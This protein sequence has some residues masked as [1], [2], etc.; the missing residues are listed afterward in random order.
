MYIFNPIESIRS[1]T[2]DHIKRKKVFKCQLCE[3]KSESKQRMGQHYDTKHRNDI[4]SEMDGYRYFYFTLTGKGNGSCVICKSE[5]EFNRT[6][7][8]YSRFCSNPECK[9]RYREEFKS[10][11]ISKYGR[12]HLLDDPEM[13]KKMLQSRSISGEY[14]WSDGSVKIPY[15]GSYE[16]D[17]LQM[18]DLKL[19][20][21]SSDILAPSPHIFVYQYQG[22]DHFYIPDF[23]VPSLNLEVEI[24]D[25]GDAKN[26]NPDSRA[27]DEIKDELMR[28]NS[29]TFNYIRIE[30]KDYTEF[31]KILSVDSQYI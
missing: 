1:I 13:Q 16:M 25:G 31:F 21:K 9:Q 11:M 26:I 18:M 2:N 20:W 22:K 29:N 14:T 24:K 23:Y 19:H 27:K 4:P 17:F 5:T 10:R 8:K 28:S 6:T 12:I 15:T 3:F 30:G 7:M